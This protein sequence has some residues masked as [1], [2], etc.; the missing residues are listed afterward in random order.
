MASPHAHVALER[1]FWIDVLRAHASHYA[2]FAPRTTGRFPH[3]A[4]SCI[5]ELHLPTASRTFAAL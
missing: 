5:F 4:P 1:I 3:V 2:M